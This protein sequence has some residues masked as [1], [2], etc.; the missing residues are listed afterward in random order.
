MG[1]GKPGAGWGSWA[2]AATSFPAGRILCFT[3]DTVYGYGRVEVASGAVGH[4]LDAYHLFSA[5]R[6]IP[7]T[8]Q[9]APNRK[10]GAKKPDPKTPSPPQGPAVVEQHRLADRPRHG[11]GR[12]ANRRGR[13]RRPG[14]EDRGRRRWPSRTSPRPAP[15]SRARR[16]SSCESSTPPTARPSRRSACPPC[17][18]STACPPP[19]ENS[20]S[21]SRTAR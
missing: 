12:R 21:A 1:K 16:A 13:P 17:R 14:Q 19:A 10:P 11:H 6:E 18:P 20:T 9:P 3:D 5:A 2:R 7:P 8:P 15:P 4:K